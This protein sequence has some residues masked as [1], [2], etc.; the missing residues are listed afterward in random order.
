MR[1]DSEVP[2][3]SSFDGVGYLQQWPKASRRRDPVADSQAEASLVGKL[4]A[5]CQTGSIAGPIFTASSLF[6]HSARS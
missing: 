5:N 6:C 1:K 4:N 3:L 2:K